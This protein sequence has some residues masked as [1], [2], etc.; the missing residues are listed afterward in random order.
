MRQSL[1]AL[2]AALTPIFVRLGHGPASEADVH[3]A[4]VQLRRLRTLLRE[5]G[6]LCPL[7]DPKWEA[8]LGDAARELG[9]QRDASV[10]TR[11][12]ER[13]LTVAR[14]ALPP[15]PPLPP[16]STS[17]Q[18]PAAGGCLA[19]PALQAA[20]ATMASLRTL[21]LAQPLGWRE[22]SPAHTRRLIARRLQRLWRSSAG[23][24]Q[25]FC[26]LPAAQQ[27]AVRKRLK[28]LRYLGELAQVYWPQGQHRNLQLRLQSA[29]D[30]LGAHQDLLTAL[31]YLEHGCAP[32]PQ[33]TAA[34][35]CLRAG[36]PTSARRAQAQLQRL[37]QSRRYWRKG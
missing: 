21:S 2:L 37:Q 9:L 26:D 1:H 4:R 31:A 19:H 33:A 32:S 22:H 17:G 6:N 7:I 20:L 36:L 16:L 12:L 8:I 27:H 29:Q 25:R 14:L 10:V 5:T 24:A 11:V 23:Q 13:E 3:E 30:A 35:L 18:A 28:R 15:L 34:A